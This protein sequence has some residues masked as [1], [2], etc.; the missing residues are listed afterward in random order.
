MLTTAGLAFSTKSAKSGKRL[1]L[2]LLGLFG[3][4]ISSWAKTGMVPAKISSA[5]KKASRN[6]LYSQS[7]S[8][9]K[10]DL[11]ASIIKIKILF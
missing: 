6:G 3:L 8:F 2:G 1:K 10:K 11:I 9:I 4:L 5:V 7:E